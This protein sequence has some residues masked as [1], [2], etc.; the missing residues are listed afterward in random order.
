[1]QSASTWHQI[2]STQTPWRLHFQYSDE[3]AT[4][5]E[6]ETQ[7]GVR[8]SWQTLLGW[9]GVSPTRSAGASSRFAAST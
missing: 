7:P 4:V 2:L 6:H 5:L 9:A 8:F 3:Q 1:M